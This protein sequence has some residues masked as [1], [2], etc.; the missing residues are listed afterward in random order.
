MTRSLPSN[1]K[2]DICDYLE[3]CAFLEGECNIEEY[4]TSED[5]DSEDSNQIKDVKRILQDR[6]HLY[7]PYAPFRIDRNRIIST[8]QDEAQRLCELHYI[9]CVYYSLYGAQG[10]KRDDSTLFEQ[11]VDIALKEY[12][13]TSQ[14]ILTSFGNNEQTIKEKI[15]E[16]LRMTNEMLGDLSLMP[17]HAKDGGIDIITFKPLDN[18]GNQ[19]IVMTDATLGK[20]WTEKRVASKL[21]HWVQYIHF[22][23]KPVPCLALTKIIPIEKFHDASVDNGLLFD[24]TRI[25]RNYSQNTS[26][27]DKLKIWWEANNALH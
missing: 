4:Y 13:H 2:S 5:D 7:A 21:A 3:Y 1:N 20:K 12:L 16:F 14:S 19:I 15:H 22:K 8:Y 26:I 6:L 10:V 18:R 17:S 25:V 24:R 9:F 27:Q 11:I 23:A